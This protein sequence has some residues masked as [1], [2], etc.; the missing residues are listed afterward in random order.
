MLHAVAVGPRQVVRQ[1]RIRI[2][3]VRRI[4]AE[5]MPGFPNDLLHVEGECVE[6]RVCPRMMDDEPENRRRGDFVY[7]K[8]PQTERAH[9]CRAVH[10]VLKVRRRERERIRSRHQLRRDAPT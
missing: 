1:K 10:Q 5:D 8:R 7:R 6:L 9:L 4:L 3:F 2:A